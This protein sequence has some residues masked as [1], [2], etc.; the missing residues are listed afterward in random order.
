MALNDTPTVRKVP[1]SLEAEQSV[2]GSILIDPESIGEIATFIT[3]DDF[4]L[5]RHREIYTAMQRLF[6]QS[7][8]I[9]AIML[10]EELVREGVYEE[11]KSREYI[12][13]LAEIVPS[14][15]NVKEYAQIVKDKSLLRSLIDVCNFI[16]LSVFS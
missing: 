15:S 9:D 11:G 16:G 10:A 5:D 8:D 12:R 4:D 14:A 7:K 6:L 1:F 3:T 2:L 13:T